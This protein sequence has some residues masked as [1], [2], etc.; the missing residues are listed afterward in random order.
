M[1]VP[2]F[3]KNVLIGVITVK[4]VHDLLLTHLQVITVLA[5]V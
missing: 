3:K 5:Y 2:K 1:E 4:N